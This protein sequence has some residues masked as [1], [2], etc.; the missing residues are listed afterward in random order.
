VC[1]YG[2]LFASPETASEYA[3]RHTGAGLE[4]STADEAFRIGQ[5]MLEQEPL[6]SVFGR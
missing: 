4:V 5:L 3:A 2:H 1:N 6:K